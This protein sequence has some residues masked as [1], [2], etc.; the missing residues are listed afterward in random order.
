[1]SGRL[2]EII[3][4]KRHS[5]AALKGS[6]RYA[7]KA[8]PRVSSQLFDNKGEANVTLAVSKL[9]R[10]VVLNGTISAT[11][12]LQCQRCMAEMSW[13]VDHSFKLG[14]IETDY[15]VDKLPD[16]IEPL[17]TGDQPI[18]VSEVVEDELL[19]ALPIVPMHDDV[20]CEMNKTNMSSGSEMAEVAEDRPNPFSVLSTLKQSKGDN[21]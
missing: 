4:P 20:D 15:E 8:L 1:M 5:A 6:G 10:L 21:T 13:P 2:P 9:G 17:L 11:L 14:V 7:L 19:L 3:D 12:V 16:D 18:T